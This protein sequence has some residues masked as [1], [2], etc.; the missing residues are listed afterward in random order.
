MAIDLEA[1]RKK[2]QQMNSGKR[3]GSNE[4]S[5]QLWKPDVGEHRIRV[6][7]WP[8]ALPGEPIA[9]RSFYYVGEN[10]AFLSP[11][12][13]GQPDPIEK[14][15]MSLFA[16]KTPEGKALGKTLFPKVYGYVPIVDLNNVDAGVQIWKFNHIIQT[17]LLG[18]F[19]DE[20]CGDFTDPLEGNDLK[21]TVTDSGKKF[22]GRSALDTAVDFRAKKTPF[23]SDEKKRQSL[24]SSIPKLDDL[25][26]YAIKTPEQIE[27]IVNAW[28]AGEPNK[29]DENKEGTVKGNTKKEVDLDELAKDLGE[30]KS[31][32][33]AKATP[34][35]Q[36]KKKD[37][38]DEVDVKPSATTSS[39]LD[40]AFNDLMGPD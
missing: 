38:D 23:L 2:I 18:F 34:T 32:S 9:E 16:D 12:Q 10:K 14:L 25:H 13:F 17:R 35:A 4:N 28:L 6:L 26:P 3:G 22:N 31:T 19:L 36:T 40:E 29:A 20:D 8:N 24:L 30:K 15:R 21:V 39:S 27:A 37:E 33:K 1:I 11:A 5:V 7:P